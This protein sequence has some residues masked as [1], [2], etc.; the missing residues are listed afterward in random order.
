MEYTKVSCFPEPDSETN[1]EILTAQLGELGFES[2]SETDDAVE[3]FIPSSA[4]REELLHDESLVNNPLFKVRF[5]TEII[6]DQNWNE[7]WEKN[8]FQ[9]LLV[10]NRCLIRAPFH[11]DT[12]KAEYEI[13]I[14]PRMAFG[15]GNHE[16]TYLMISAILQ[17]DLQGKQVLDMGCGTGI[18]GILASMRGADMVKAI[19]IDEWSYKNTLEN[20][21][22]N[23][24]T[25]IDVAQGDAGLLGKE[26]FDVIY[27]NIQRNILLQDLPVYASV[28]CKDAEI[29]VSGFYRED[30]PAISAKAEEVG[31]KPA[32]YEE[33]NNWVAA[34]FI[35]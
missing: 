25:N 35:R 4:Y 20:A 18:L 22:I 13:V 6:P 3:A 29:I 31:L 26:K 15:T 11:K 24:V 16:T 14:D 8:Y 10:E 5:Q 7:V 2:F 19:D 23:N 1:R 12:P 27:A 30:L 9:P 34:R 32:G 21:E 17:Q 33:R 28:M